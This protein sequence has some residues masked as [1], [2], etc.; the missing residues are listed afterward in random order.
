MVQFLAK[1]VKPFRINYKLKYLTFNFDLGVK[2]PKFSFFNQ[3]P[4]VPNLLLHYGAIFS[5]IDQAPQDL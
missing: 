3:L 5:Q 2:V 4:K 1:S